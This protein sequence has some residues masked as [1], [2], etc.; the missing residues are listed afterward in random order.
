MINIS[1][2]KAAV[3]LEIAKQKKEECQKQQEVEE[4]EACQKA[5]E[6]ERL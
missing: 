4:A 2:A 3:R 1:I 6:T 5:E